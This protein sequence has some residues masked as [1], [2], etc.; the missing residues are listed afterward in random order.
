MSDQLVAKPFSSYLPIAITAMVIALVPGALVTS[1]M[2]IFFPIVSSDYGV[3]T[4]Q[5][6][7]YMTIGSLIMAF[8][9]PFV[10][11]LAA[12]HDLRFV[13]A[14]LIGVIVLAYI[15]LSFSSSYIQFV[16]SA[17]LMMPCAMICIGLFNPTLI[18]RWFKDRAGAIV[19]FAAAMTGVGGVL[20]L[21]ID[22]AVIDAAGYR[23]AFLAN[24]IIIAV[25]A[26]P[27]MLFAIRN[28]PSDR[29]MLPYI[30][31]H[32]SALKTS[33]ESQEA[34]LAKASARNWSV[35][36][37]IA[38]K[39]VSFWI[40]CIAAGLAN[41]TVLVAQFFPTYI[42]S[43]ENAGIVAFVSGTGLATFTMAGQAV[44]K[45]LLGAGSDFSPKSTVIVACAVGIIAILFIWL[46]AQTVLLPIGGFIFGMF[47]ASPIVLLPLVAGAIYGTGE[48]YSI[49]WGRT[50]LPS[51]ILA[52]P[53]GVLW[54]WISETFGGFDAV[55]IAGI[56]SIVI[57]VIL[58]LVTMKLAERLPHEEGVIPAAEKINAEQASEKAAEQ[59]A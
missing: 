7:I 15:S 21:Q 33:K 31:I 58:I 50:M 22:Q 17:S 9:G 8:S 32:K 56:G 40:F 3:A 13:G 35:K 39:D 4:S 30:N 20:F 52:A 49:I 47:Y 57:F 18:N 29:G 38:T 51:G 42:S 59:N 41:A 55:F 14:G 10:G 37:S 34:A 19:G 54:P 44:C 24:A 16:I 25:I 28:K 23:M 2:S 43:L 1:C 26:L 5:I 36:A 53:A 11:K 12:T 46:G 6:T 45:F 27:C 48:E